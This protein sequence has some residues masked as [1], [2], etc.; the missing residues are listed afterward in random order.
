MPSTIDSLNVRVSLAQQ[1]SDNAQCNLSCIEILIH[2]QHMMHQGILNK[3]YKSF[4]L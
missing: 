3:C 2:D 4:L 1:Y